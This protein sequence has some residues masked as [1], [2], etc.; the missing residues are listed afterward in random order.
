MTARG[1]HHVGASLGAQPVKVHVGA[2]NLDNVLLAGLASQTGLAVVVKEAVNTST[3]HVDARRPKNAHTPGLAA[4]VSRACGEIRVVPG[5]LGGERRQRVRVALVV[6]RLRLDQSHVDVLSVGDLV[7][8]QLAVL[9]S[10][11]VHPDRTLV[12]Q[13][14]TT[15]VEDADLVVA[16][17]VKVVVTDP[18]P[19]VLVVQSSILGD[20]HQHEGTEA[21]RIGRNGR[22]GVL[23][24]LV[25][26][27]LSAS[28]AT[29]TEVNVPHACRSLSGLLHI[30]L[31]EDSTR[32]RAL[33]REDEIR[34]L[35][36]T[37]I[38]GLTDLD[39]GDRVL[40]VGE[41]LA[42]CHQDRPDLTS[43]FD[44]LGDLQG[45]GDDVVTMVEVNDLVLCGTVQNLLESGRVIGAAITL[46][47]SRLDT[48]EGGSGNGLVL[49]FRA[50]EHIALAVKKL[51]GEL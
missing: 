19:A 24:A 6:R 29:N 9:R 16:G 47:A 26:L 18:V 30:P 44:V 45:R 36:R 35:H 1:S 7:V 38:A 21:L 48:D 8:V 14:D 25:I 17:A 2:V 13:Q 40:L 33:G 28:G 43:D 27:K 32:S 4:G 42:R 11:T 12:L 49:R 3:E 5:R 41:G 23:G 50:L 37:N 20:V 15:A 10:G 46:G 31:H 51:L 22:L 34:K 39:H